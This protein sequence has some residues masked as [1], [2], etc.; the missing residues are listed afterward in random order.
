MPKGVPLPGDRAA[1][2]A[3]NWP[4]RHANDKDAAG[5]MHHT[6][7]TGAGQAA[8][9]NHD[10]SINALSEKPTPGSNDILVIEDSGDVFAKKKIK[11]SSLPSGGGGVDILAVQVF[12]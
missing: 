8:A 9:G 6:L 5:G 12:S 3:A 7:G 4:D 11:I 2:D 1:W 10:H